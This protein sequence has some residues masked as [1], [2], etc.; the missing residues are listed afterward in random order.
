MWR[1]TGLFQLLGGDWTYPLLYC[2]VPATMT[3]NVT[4]AKHN[5]MAN[6]VH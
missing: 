2:L 3:E 6:L 1:T 4:P 5:H